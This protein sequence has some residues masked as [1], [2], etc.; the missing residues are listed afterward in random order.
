MC[1]D[2]FNIIH[3]QGNE[4]RYSNGYHLLPLRAVE[5]PKLKVLY[6]LSLVTLLEMDHRSTI[7]EPFLLS[8]GLIMVSNLMDILAMSHVP[9]SMNTDQLMGLKL[10][11]IFSLWWIWSEKYLNIVPFLRCHIDMPQKDRKTVTTLR[12][13]VRPYS[14]TNC[15]SFCFVSNCVEIH[16][17]SS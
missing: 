9:S 16:N 5:P 2:M 15:N 1:V 12:W 4:N 11:Q 7:S 6:R 3:P 14:M 8:V 17:F 10:F 13:W